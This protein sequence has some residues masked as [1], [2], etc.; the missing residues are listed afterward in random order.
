MWLD[1]SG[2]LMMTLKTLKIK[3]QNKNS[4]V[5]RYAKKNYLN[6]AR[7]LFIERTIIII[8]FYN[9]YSF[10]IFDISNK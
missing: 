1:G 9:D 3:L 4:V 10:F 5:N 7:I 8:L 6:L 2:V